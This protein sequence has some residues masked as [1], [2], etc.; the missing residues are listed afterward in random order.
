M[1]SL[2]ALLAGIVV[3]VA[4][5]ELVVRSGS[6]LAG[7][8]GVPPMVIGLTVVAVGTS[9]PELAIGIDSALQG[10]G[11]LAVGNIAGTNT[12]NLLLVLGMSAALLPLA[13][14]RRSL[15]IDLPVMVIA[16][17]AMLVMSLDGH[18]SRAEGVLLILGGLVH[19][20]VTVRTARRRG[21]RLDEEY[22]HEFG[23][24]TDRHGRSL[25]ID[26]AL[27]A[28][29]IGVIVIGADVLVDAASDL[30][31]NLGVSDALIGLTVV[32]IGTSA[33]EFVTM[34]VATLRDERDIAI[35][36]IL[37]SST[38]NIL[39]ILGVAMV[40]PSAGIDVEPRLVSIDIP[41]MTAVALVCIPVFISGRKV[42]RVEGG[43]FVAAYLLYLGLLISSNGS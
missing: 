10:V 9:A 42:T 19:T 31:R 4:G 12:V 23:P 25:A 6:R 40:V 1:S 41:V 2:L 18:L 27:L 17:L 21:G 13:L 5:A 39:V 32:A 20:V 29:G 37:G 33:P 28:V 34:V 8:L 43:I 22:A 38:Y 30:A 3:L 14:D 35:G 7:R 11:S 36:N 15:R 24:P 16:A 26:V